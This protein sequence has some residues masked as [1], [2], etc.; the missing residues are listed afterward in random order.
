MRP[1]LGRQVGRRKII[2]DAEE[3][4]ADNRAGTCIEELADDGGGDAAMPSVSPW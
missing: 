4:A 3:H 1:I 2:E